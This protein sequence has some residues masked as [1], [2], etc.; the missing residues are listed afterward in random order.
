MPRTKAKPF[1]KYP[2]AFTIAVRQAVRQPGAW[3]TIVNELTAAQ[4]K[5][6][7]I[8][9]ESLRNGLKDPGSG[10]ED[11]DA[12][13]REGK[14]HF[15]RLDFGGLDGW[16]V[17]VRCDIVRTYLGSAVRTALDQK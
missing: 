10:Q 15:R 1:H 5:T 9:L 2:M 3:R 14:L 13:A 12:A 6:I 17:Q 11:L 16:M 8:K 7:M 4:A